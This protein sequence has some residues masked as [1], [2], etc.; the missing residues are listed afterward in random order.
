MARPVPRSPHGSSL[1]EV[2]IAMAVMA[3]GL[4][5]M[6]NLHMVGITSTAAGRRHTIAT[7]LAQELLSGLERLAFTDPHLSENHT[8]QGTAA[9][10]P[11]TALFGS[12]VT[13]AGSVRGGA[14]E[15]SDANPVAGVRLDSQMREKAEGSARLVNSALLAYERRWTVWGLVSPQAGAAGTTPG[16]KLIAVSVVWRD[17]PFARPREVVLYSQIPNAGSIVA[18]LANSP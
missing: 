4:L 10:P 1:I 18:G 3:V 13:G 11:A 15:W 7:A 6:W 9:G 2:M 14:H 17:P 12:L 16:V 8:G 5:A